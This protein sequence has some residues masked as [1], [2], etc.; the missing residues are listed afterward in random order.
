M[1][2]PLILT[3]NEREILLDLIMGEF[4]NLKK[5]NGNY[6]RYIEEYQKELQAI[7]HKI[8]DNFEEE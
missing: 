4:N 1:Q 8:V 2:E 7:H 5:L 6:H 3:Q